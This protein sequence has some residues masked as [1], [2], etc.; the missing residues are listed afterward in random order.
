LDPNLFDARHLLGYLYLRE[1]RFGEAIE[2]LRTAAE[3]QPS[4][5]SVWEYLA[6]AYHQNGSRDE[7]LAAAKNARRTAATVE[8][9]SRMEATL[10]LID[11]EPETIVRSL[12]PSPY[13]SPFAIPG[14]GPKR[15]SEEISTARGGERINGLLVQVD[16]LGP[17][18]RLHII[19]GPDKTFLLV[20]DAS[21]VMLK[22]ISSATAELAC[23]PVKS[24]S[25]AVEYRP[26][27]NQSYG[28]SGEVSVIEFR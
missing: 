22:G 20:R 13:G 15:E 8:E 25:V 18:A 5:S 24:R 6:L 4:R 28:T 10:R 14:P 26:N 27:R 11:S 9:L 2:Q 7:A 17:T 23:G 19:G 1:R 3:L 21:S 12:P 16:C